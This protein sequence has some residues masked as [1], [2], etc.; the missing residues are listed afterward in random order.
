[1]PIDAFW[2]EHAE[3]A[4]ETSLPPDVHWLEWTPATQA[5]DFERVSR[6]MLGYVLEDLPTL[7][8][9]PSV[10]VEGPQVVP[11]LLPDDSRAVFLIPTPEFQRANLSP[12]PMPSSDPARALANRLVK[13]RLYA[14]RVAELA[15]ELGYVV[16]DVDGSRSTDELCAII[17]DAFPD[18]FRD[19]EPIDLSGVRRWENEKIARNV[20]AWRASGDHRTSDEMPVPFACECGR[21]GCGERAMVTLAEFDR[22][23]RVLAPGH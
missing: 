13:D 16:V 12:R 17:E 14:D 18:Y 2:Y 4:G 15:R 1:M 7:P 11:D 3:R 5:A 6:L 9:Q 20:R 21:L 10:L 22:A 8:P 23:E 19:S